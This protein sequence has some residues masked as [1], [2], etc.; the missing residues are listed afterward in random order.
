MTDVKEHRLEL[1]LS[2]LNWTEMFRT[3][4]SLLKALKAFTSQSEGFLSSS[5]Q[6]DGMQGTWNKVA[7]SIK[8]ILG[9]SQKQTLDR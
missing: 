1:Q 3:G 7:T 6:L 2:S 5:Q 4:E 8:A 9:L